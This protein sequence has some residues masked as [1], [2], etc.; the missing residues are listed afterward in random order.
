MDWAELFS[1][2]LGSQRDVTSWNNPYAGTFWPGAAIYGPYGGA[3]GW[4]AYNPRTEQY[5]RGGAAYGPYSS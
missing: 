1:L 3:G 4:A 2:S 5:A